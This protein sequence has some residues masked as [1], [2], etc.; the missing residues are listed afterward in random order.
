MGRIEKEITEEVIKAIYSREE[1]PHKMIYLSKFLEAN[2]AKEYIGV[3]ANRIS[4][5]I[6]MEHVSFDFL[7]TGDIMLDHIGMEECRDILEG[8]ASREAVDKYMECVEARNVCADAYNAFLKTLRETSEE[9]LKKMIDEPHKYFKEEKQE[10]R[11]EVLK[12]EL[13]ARKPYTRVFM[14]IKSKINNIGF[15]I[16]NFEIIFVINRIVKRCIARNMEV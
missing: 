9:T 7:D 11:R 15:Y 4:E 2:G 3:C 13:R 10:Q 6:D 14:M 1:L 16:K 8:Y 12:A 5:L